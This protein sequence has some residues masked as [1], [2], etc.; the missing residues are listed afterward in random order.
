MK[1]LII[2]YVVFVVPGRVF[3]TTTYTLSV[4]NNEFYTE[5]R[6]I[7]VPIFRVLYVVINLNNMVNVFVFLWMIKEFRI[8]VKNPFSNSIISRNRPSNYSQQSTQTVVVTT[9]V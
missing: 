9:T 5:Y 7:F 2:V 3:M 6:D 1:Y 4:T 8:F